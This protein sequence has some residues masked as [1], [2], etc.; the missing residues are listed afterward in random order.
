[1]FPTIAEQ[2][3]AMRRAEWQEAAMMPYETYRLYDIERPKTAAELRFADERTGRLAAATAGTFRRLTALLRRQAPSPQVPRPA[4]P[5]CGDDRI[6]K[7][8]ERMTRTVGVR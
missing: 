8:D 6:A 5:A 1:M 3:A 2:L 4:Q 7:D